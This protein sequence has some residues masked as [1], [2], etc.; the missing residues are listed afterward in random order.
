MKIAASDV[1]LDSSTGMRSAGAEGRP[2]LH[3]VAPDW[4][5]VTAAI[6]SWLDGVFDAPVAATQQPRNVHMVELTA[7]GG[8]DQVEARLREALD[9]HGL[10]LFARI[11][12]AAGARKADVELEAPSC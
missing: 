12:H 3:M 6:N 1:E 4:Q 10:Q 9:A 2:H 8:A 11:D 5:E 7:S